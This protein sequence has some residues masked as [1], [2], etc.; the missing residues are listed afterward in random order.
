MSQICFKNLWIVD[1]SDEMNV[2]V[3]P[4]REVLLFSMETNRV[5]RLTPI[6]IESPVATYEVG[7]HVLVRKARYDKLSAL[8]RKWSGWFVVIGVYGARCWLRN[9]D[10]KVSRKGCTFDA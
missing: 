3:T 9:G 8:V 1:G 10:R 5:E 2:D 7:E 4:R 6:A